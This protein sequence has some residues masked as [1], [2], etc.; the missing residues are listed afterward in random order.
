[1]QTGASTVRTL[2]RARAQADGTQQGPGVPAR[3]ATLGVWRV[4]RGSAVGTIATGL[5]WAGHVWA[6]GDR[7]GPWLLLTAA[8]G[9]ITASVALSRYRWSP[10]SLLVM[11]LAV[12]LLLHRLF[13]QG[14]PTATVAHT[15]PSGHLL[16]GPDVGGAMTV[17]HM[18]A[19]V[20][21]AWLL[22]R[23][24]DWLWLLLELL[25][26]R[27]TRLLRPLHLSLATNPT[28]LTPA[29]TLPGSQVGLGAWSLR[30]PPVVSR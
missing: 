2:S 17:A 6:G 16:V 21:T 22:A 7:P 20:A 14:A 1:M 30:G 18:L 10:V 11:L 24:E 29:Y 27:S 4:L 19:A 25:A 26:L 13:D 12:Q 8:L 23:G 28:P 9:V 5:A 15:H 3:P